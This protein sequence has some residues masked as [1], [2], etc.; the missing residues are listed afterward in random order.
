M[1]DDLTKLQKTLL[2]EIAYYNKPDVTLSDKAKRVN[3]SLVISKL[4]SNYIQIEN[5]KLRRDQIA[6]T[7]K[8]IDRK[9]CKK[10]EK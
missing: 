2:D 5:L 10:R 6:T 4:A 8:D 7:N 1:K 9:V 3:Q